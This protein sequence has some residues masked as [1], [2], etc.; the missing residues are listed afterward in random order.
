MFFFLFLLLISNKVF[1]FILWMCVVQPLI[2]FTIYSTQI[3]RRPLCLTWFFVQYWID[4]III[5]TPTCNYDENVSFL[6]Q[7]AREK[8]SNHMKT[9]SLNDVAWSF[10]RFFFNK[11]K[12]KCGIYDKRGFDKKT[13]CNPLCVLF[14]YIFFFN[15][16]FVA[17]I[18][19]TFFFA[20]YVINGLWLNLWNTSQ[21]LHHHI[22][23][24]YFIKFIWRHNVSVHFFHICMFTVHRRVQFCFYHICY[25]EIENAKE[26]KERQMKITS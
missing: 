17:V 25:F 5:G 10:P 15:F 18:W 12:G 6:E 9:M 4:I 1:F 22:V 16:F 2:G 21:R 3:I 7:R 13:N 19:L 24:W 26:M 8:K 20:G 23:N 14:V 11:K